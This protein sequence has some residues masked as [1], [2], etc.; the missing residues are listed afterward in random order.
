MDSGGVRERHR[1]KGQDG[2]PGKT[3]CPGHCA[4][5]L[6]DGITKSPLHGGLPTDRLVAEWWLNSRHVQARLSGQRPEQGKVAVRVRLPRNIGELKTSDAEA[7]ARV[8]KEIR[9]EFQ[10]WLRRG[11]V[12]TG[13]ELSAEIAN[14]LLEMG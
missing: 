6:S 14:Y 9:E 12:V 1:N 7:A 3:S 2:P 13:L 5:L 8:Q 4:R 11:Y 10:H